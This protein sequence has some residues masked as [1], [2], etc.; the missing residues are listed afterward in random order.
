[1]RLIIRLLRYTHTVVHVHMYTLYGRVHGL[2]HKQC[3]ESVTGQC[4]KQC[5]GEGG[6]VTGWD[7]SEA[8][9]A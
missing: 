8:L 1:M 5:E 2:N 6:S 3:M 9:S 4:R 7:I